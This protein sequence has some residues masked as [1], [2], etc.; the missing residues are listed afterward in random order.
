VNPAIESA[1]RL[2]A[3]L[4]RAKVPYALMGGIA[5]QVH[6]VTT[7]TYD[8]DLTILPEDVDRV[9]R[10]LASVGFEVPEEHRK[11]FQ[12]TLAGMRKVRLLDSHSSPPVEVDVFIVTTPFQRASFGRV[13]RKAIGSRDVAVFSPEDLILYKLMAW[14]PKDRGAIQSILIT[15]PSL[16]RVYL[17][18]WA[19]KLGVEQRLS[20]S[21]AQA[22][23]FWR[24]PGP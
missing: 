17:A 4:D 22:D 19:R 3:A 8:V 2:V 21:L 9:L 18:D 23:A 6:S 7:T 1:L 13:S 5:T 12:D 14:R 10:M 16:D 15:N 24:E 20:E 11:G